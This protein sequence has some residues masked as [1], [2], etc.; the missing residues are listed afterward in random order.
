[1]ELLR[2]SRDVWGREVIAGVSWDLL[3]L[4]IAVGAIVILAH[5]A[6]RYLRRRRGGS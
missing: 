6:Y 4:A 1:M 2:V 3:P 5:A